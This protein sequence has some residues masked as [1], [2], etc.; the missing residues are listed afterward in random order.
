[1]CKLML[2]IVIYIL[3]S[4]IRFM[5]LFLYDIRKNTIYE[6]TLLGTILLL[7]AKI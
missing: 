4:F 6:G 3:N 5:R 7:N 2:I 1:M